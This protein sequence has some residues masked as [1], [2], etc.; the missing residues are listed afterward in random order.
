MF[1]EK[2]VQKALHF[3]ILFCTFAKRRR[4]AEKQGKIRLSVSD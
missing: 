2:K 4:N 1:S 3:C